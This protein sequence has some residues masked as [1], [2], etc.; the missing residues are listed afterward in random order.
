M[1]AFTAVSVLS[2]TRFLRRF[3]ATGLACGGIKKRENNVHQNSSSDRKERQ[4]KVD[5]RAAAEIASKQKKSPAKEQLVA[6][7]MFSSLDLFSGR[8]HLLGL[9]TIPALFLATLLSS[10]K[11]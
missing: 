6:S 1:L 10:I 2:R 5:G 8:V 11:L 9:N 4:K 3:T 7:S